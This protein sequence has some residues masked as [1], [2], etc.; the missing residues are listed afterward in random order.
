MMVGPV[1]QLDRERISAS[2]AGL[3]ERLL[4]G[5]I[6][7][8]AVTATSLFSCELEEDSEPAA[9]AP[10]FPAKPIPGPAAPLPESL[11]HP[12]CVDDLRQIEEH[13][14]DL[15][16]R[17][18]PATVAVTIGG[19]SASAVVI[20][21]DG[22][23]LTAAHVV[24]QAGS[25]V[26]FTFPDGKTAHGKSLGAN[27][28]VDSGLMQ[29]VD[30]GPWPYVDIGD[31]TDVQ[32]GDWVVALGH[33]GGF[34]P[35][36]PLVARLGRII[37]LT[38]REVRTD[39]T[40]VGGDSGGPLFDLNGRVVAIHSRISD[41]TA[42]NFHVPIASYLNTW[43]RLAKGEQWGDRRSSRA[44]V[45]AWGF[46]HPDGCILERVSEDSPAFKAGLKVGDIITMLNG[47]KV[48]DS[49][50]FVELVTDTKP[51]DEITLEYIRDGV[52]LGMLITVE[53]RPDR[54]RRRDWE[55]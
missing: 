11:K 42:A 3:C 13:V 17:V 28:A 7:F 9:S 54:F 32:R 5:L 50:S 25:E 12:S 8:L 36:R 2:A 14:R 53:R 18:G 20:S 24:G 44:W 52:E 34:D 37:R 16:H 1:V 51:G 35:D 30:K 33:P 15:V 29:I 43:D 48:E 6:F 10:A 23:V 41:S 45:G 26:S 4:F 21:H 46:D 19:S 47:Q 55:Q 49:S 22:L 39:C 31:P 40:I 27:H 38:S